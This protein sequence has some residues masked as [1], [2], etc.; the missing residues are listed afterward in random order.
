LTAI[1]FEPDVPSAQ[2]KSAVLLAGLHA[3]GVTS[4]RESLPTRDHTERALQVFGG[5]VSNVDSTVSV[6]GGQRLRGCDLVVPGDISSAAFWMVAASALP[7]SGSW[8][9]SGASG[10]AST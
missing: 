2:V 7:G 4:V 6:T 3:D 9:S 8:M 10:P 5:T 1:N